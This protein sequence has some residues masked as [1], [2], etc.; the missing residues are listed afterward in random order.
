MWNVT[1]TELKRLDVRML[2]F[3]TVAHPE[4][5]IL[6]TDLGGVKNAPEMVASVEH[7]ASAPASLT[8]SS[9]TR[10]AAGAAMLARSAGPASRR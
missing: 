4:I 1:W 3:E 5:G 10:R 8:R 6:T 2:N 7:A 9:P